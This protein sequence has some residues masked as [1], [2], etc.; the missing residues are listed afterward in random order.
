[1]PVAQGPACEVAALLRAVDANSDWF[2][3]E[4]GRLERLQGNVSRVLPNLDLDAVINDDDRFAVEEV[5]QA[6][7][8]TLDWCRKS[9]MGSLDRAVVRSHENGT[10]LTAELGWQLAKRGWLQ[11]PEPL[12]PT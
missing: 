10:E 12:G 8:N 9:L 7:N 3:L 2:D 11:E 4:E 6:Q 1:M 5:R